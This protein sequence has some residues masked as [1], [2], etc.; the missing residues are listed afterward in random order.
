LT[1]SPVVGELGN[2]I[3]APEKRTCNAPGTAFVLAVTSTTSFRLV[4]SS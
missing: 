4:S 1:Q 2:V 3:V